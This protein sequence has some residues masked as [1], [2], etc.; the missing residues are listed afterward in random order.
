MQVV[1]YRH[2]DL[3]EWGSDAKANFGVVR[4]AITLGS[5]DGVHAGHRKIITRLVKSA[6]RVGLRSIL[7][8][9][10]PHPRLVLRKE[11]TPLLK[12]LTT[13]DEKRSLLAPLGL[14]VLVVIEFTKEFAKTSAETFVK[15]ILVKKLGLADIV[16]GYDHGF[17]KD[18]QGTIET[19][20]ALSK[21]YGFG[22][23][24][25]EE[26]LMDGKHLSST[27]VR[28]LLEDGLIEE[29]NHFLQTPYCLTGNVIKGDR[30]GH[31][32]GFPTANLEIQSPHKLIPKSGVYVADVLIDGVCY[33]SM[34]NIGYRPTVNDDHQLSIEAHILKFDG[35]LYGRQLRFAMLSRIRDEKKFSNIDALKAQLERDKQIAG[36]YVQEFTCIR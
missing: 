1:Q 15:D 18:R 6:K 17:G 8:T 30:L 22:I 29:A 14:D 13:F 26:Q 10:E 9:F 19:L 21:V 24:I 4:S 23:E 27:A 16:I 34:M 32:I 36:A 11:G 35:D 2:D 25:T 7:I 5:Y 12:L 20:Q 31:Q 28:Q 33:R 3:Y